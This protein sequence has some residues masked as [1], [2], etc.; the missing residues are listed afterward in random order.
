MDWM[1]LRMNKK[2]IWGW[3]APVYVVTYLGMIVDG[4]WIGE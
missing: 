1:R 2:V 4:V 3:P